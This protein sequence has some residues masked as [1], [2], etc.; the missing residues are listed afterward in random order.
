MKRL[1]VSIAL[2]LNGSLQAAEQTVYFDYFE[3]LPLF[4]RQVYPE[5]GETLYCDRKFG[6][7]RGRNINIEHV[8]PMSW[9]MRSTGCY[10]RDACRRTSRRFNQIESDMHN[11]Y[12]S[13]REINK[14]RG[15]SPFGIVK[16]EARRFGRCDFELDS[17]QR[18]AEPTPASRGN[19]A[20][21]MFH[22]KESYGLEIFTRQGEML[23]RWHREDPPDEAEQRR[24]SIIEKL[25]GTRNRFIDDPEAAESLRF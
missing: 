12:P 7:S 4:W 20:R 6:R 15:S 23:Q 2:L 3:V 17:K 1:I 19:I 10:S 21:A 9:V 16:G 11:F 25:Q 18:I 8:Y 5:G 14:I 13:L 24:N 22:M